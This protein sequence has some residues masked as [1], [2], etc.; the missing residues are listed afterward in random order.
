V[1]AEALA[2]TFQHQ[3]EINSAHFSPDGKLV[4]TASED[5]SARLW[6][7][8]T[9]L[10]VADPFRHKSAVTQARFSPDGQWLVTASLDG[11][12]RIWQAPFTPG[13]ETILPNLLE[14]VSGRRLT[15]QQVFQFIHRT[16]VLAF[17]NADAFA[18]K[19]KAARQWLQWFFSDPSERT[20]SPASSL[21]VPEYVARLIALDSPASLAES[22]RLQ[23]TNSHARARL[24]EKLA[25]M[26]DVPQR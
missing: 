25:V 15:E 19:D 1:T 24:A 7:A 5:G 20:I 12:A 17:R 13:L 9:G 16:N 6:D 21:N 18:L 26:P 10:E 22:L 3:A 23:W 11:T 2:E 4:L 8:G 14:A